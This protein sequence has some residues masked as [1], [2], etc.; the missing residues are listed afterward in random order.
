MGERE[1]P[2]AWDVL[3]ERAME[4]GMCVCVCVKWKNQ[5]PGMY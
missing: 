4:R 5:V 1:E 3:A 2:S